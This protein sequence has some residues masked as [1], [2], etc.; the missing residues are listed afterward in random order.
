MNI[1]PT[2]IFLRINRPFVKRKS[3]YLH[4]SKFKL[5]EIADVFV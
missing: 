3:A 5:V 1:F 2:R 4:V